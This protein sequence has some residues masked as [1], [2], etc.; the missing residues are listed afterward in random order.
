MYRYLIVESKKEIK[1]DE[2]V[3]V[4]LFSEFIEFTKIE[5]ET[6]ALHL[7]YDRESDVSFLEVVL[8]IMSD[9]LSDLR[10]YVSYQFEQEQ[11]LLTH[12]KYIKNKLAQIP[13]NK[14]VFLDDKIILR[15]FLNQVDSMMKQHILKKYANDLIMIDSI[16]NYL[17]SNQN[18]S[19]ASKKIYVHRNTLIQRI[20]KFKEITGFDVRDF[21]DAFLIYHLIK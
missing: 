7:F 3:I 16:K 5:T 13:F 20:D 9:T 14:F 15:N 18:T 11:D 4:S 17:E 12:M 10:I 2:T 1:Q 21:N 6:H 19:V 8:N